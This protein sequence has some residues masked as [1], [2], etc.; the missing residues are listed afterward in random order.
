MNTKA[1]NINFA[2]M[3][4]ALMQHVRAKAIKAGSKIVYRENT[5]II[6]ENP[7]TNTKIILSTK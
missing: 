3:G 1:V 6:E 4:N 7:T 5:V 2:I